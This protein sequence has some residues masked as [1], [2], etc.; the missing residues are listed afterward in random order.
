MFSDT[1]VKN[2]KLAVW[3]ILLIIFQ[4]VICKYI[5]VDGIIPDL[6]FVFIVSFV[7]LEE[8][9]AYCVAIPVI[10]GFLIDVLSR[11]AFG[12]G[13]LSYTYTALLCYALGEHFF[14]EKLWFAVPMIFLATFASESVF[15]LF[16]VSAFKISMIFEALK[17]VVLPTAIY[18]TAVTF[19]IYPILKKTIYSGGRELVRVPKN[20]NR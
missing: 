19:L 3:I 7:V 10:C 2:F 9:F 12:T 15:F 17:E 13:V 1:V 16:S 11:R 8:K 14:K 18:N 4:T 20:R 6:M 5:A